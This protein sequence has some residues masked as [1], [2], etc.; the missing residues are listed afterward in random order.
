MRKDPYTL[1]FGREPSQVIP[2]ASTITEI[3]ET[4]DEQIPSQQVRLITGARG[5]GKTVLMTEVSARLRRRDNWVVVELN[6][7]RDMLLSLAAD[8]CRR[9]SLAELFQSARIG[10]SFF[11]FGFRVSGS[12]PIRHIE[13]TLDMLLASLQGH[14][15]MPLI[16]VET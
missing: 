12:V 5:S 16:C 4:L 15:K 14:G 8:P 7:E 3:A 10:L 13:V 2:R 1:V 9:Q 11:G 6:P